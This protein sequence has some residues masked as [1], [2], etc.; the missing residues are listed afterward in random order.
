MRKL[1]VVSLLLVIAP[2]GFGAMFLYR[3]NSFGM[4]LESIQSYRRDQTEWVMQVQRSATGEIRRLFDNST[5]TRRWETVFSAKSRERT[6]REY[7]GTALVAL[8]LYN[9]AGFL[10]QEEQYAQGVLSQKTLLTYA[11]GRLL[12]VTVQAGDGTV[13]YTDTYL[14]ATSGA[15]RQVRR[16]PT[17]GDASLSAYVYGRAGL[18][19]ERTTLGQTANLERY[20]SRGRLIHRERRE[21]GAA[22]SREDFIF[23]PDSDY[24]QSSV[25]RFA[26]D[27]KKTERSYDEKG[28]LK[29]EITTT[30]GS[31][32][33]TIMYTR[34]DQDRVTTKIRRGAIGLE[35][36]KYSVDDTG[37]VTREDYSVG[38]SLARVTAYGEEKLRTEEL[39]KDGAVFLKVYYDGDTRLREEVYVDGDLVRERRYK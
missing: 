22:I 23:R 6:E 34:D 26:D 10:L 37:K 33:E 4:L 1:L 39:Y 15:L 29:A 13:L 31:V 20:D 28:L 8:R 2:G 11:G 12:R 30:A 21:T 35:V 5:E 32:V 25:E 24:L 16:T 36:W 9:A 19:E 3:S 38:G 18:S 7:A 14:Y 17:D 27:R